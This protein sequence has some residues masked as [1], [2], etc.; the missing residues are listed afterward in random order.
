MKI[1]VTGGA[2]FLGSSVVER[3]RSA[4]HKA[5][6]VVRSSTTDLRSKDAVNR[7]IYETSPDIVIHLAA[8]VGGIGAN[9]QNP[10]VFFYDN[11]TMGINLIDTVGRLY[12]IKKFIMV[13]TVCSYPANCP[14]P[15]VESSLWDGY[16]EITN[17]PYG[18]AKRALYTMLDAYREQYGLNST[19]LIPTNLY[20]PRDNFND[21]TSHVIPALIKKILNA[22][23]RNLADVICWGTGNA[24]RDFLYVND[25]ADAVVRTI[26]ADVGGLI[27]LGGSGEIT[28]K[29]LVDKIA[30]LIG[31]SGNIVWDRSKP[32]GQMRRQVSSDKAKQVLGWQPSTSMDQGLIET[33]RWYQEQ[34]KI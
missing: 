34:L 19:V 27:N 8:T 4:G 32:D 21:D 17:A 25:A 10:A 6:K 12:S 1:L 15:F 2:G 20:G 5:I 13:G 14:T 24:S 30:D 33:L 16:P 28:I 31:F 11:M 3:L 26:G 29:E 22:K 7:L 18:I 9:Q 23:E